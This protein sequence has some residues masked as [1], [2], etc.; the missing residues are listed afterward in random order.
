VSG[1]IWS[2]FVI[3]CVVSGQSFVIFIIF[4]LLCTVG[5]DYYWIGGIFAK[6]KGSRVH[7]AD[8]FYQYRTQTD[9]D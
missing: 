5:D 2:V 3:V 7:D 1:R 4:S 8:I 9:T 6:K